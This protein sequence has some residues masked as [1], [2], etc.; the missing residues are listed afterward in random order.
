MYLLEPVSMTNYSAP[1]SQGNLSFSSQ[2]PVNLSLYSN[3]T[4]AHS[5]HD[6]NTLEYRFYRF[7]GRPHQVIAFVLSMIA[8]LLNVMSLLAAIQVRSRINT[9]FCFIIS[10]ALSD[11]IIGVSICSHS[12]LQQHPLP[13]HL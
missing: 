9:H 10:L 2:F 13:L 8:I 5:S 4:A 7:L 6:G 1:L 11:I 12:I 3:Y